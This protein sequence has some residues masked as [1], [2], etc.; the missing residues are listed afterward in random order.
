MTG[1]WICGLGYGTSCCAVDSLQGWGGGEFDLPIIEDEIRGDP[2]AVG[3]SR[4]SGM[5]F[6]CYG[7]IEK[8]LTAKTLR[9]CA[10]TLR[11]RYSSRHVLCADH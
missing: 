10:K 2:C 3:V 11:C 4:V 9:L 5:R 1:L 6:L 8:G 7:V